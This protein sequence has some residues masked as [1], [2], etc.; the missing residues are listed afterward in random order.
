VQ[1]PAGA[2][3]AR[4]RPEGE[5]GC[6]TSCLFRGAAVERVQ[7]HASL[8]STEVS[9]MGEVRVLSYN[10]NLLPVFV[11]GV[12]HGYKDERLFEF[13]KRMPHYDIIALQEG[14]LIQLTPSKFR[15]MNSCSY[16]L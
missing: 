5:G 11:R 12:G 9:C 8:T 15:K 7:Y 16:I 3:P 4:C 6:N 10:L 13:I 1:T 2:G 14:M